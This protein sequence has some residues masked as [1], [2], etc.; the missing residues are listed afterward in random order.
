MCFSNAN[1]RNIY[2]LGSLSISILQVPISLGI[3]GCL[4]RGGKPRLGRGDSS[5]SQQ[6]AGL[7]KRGGFNPRLSDK[8]ALCRM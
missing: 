4:S 6:L 3:L 5:Q 2:F 1:F 7:M 8:V